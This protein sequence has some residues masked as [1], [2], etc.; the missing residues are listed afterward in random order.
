MKNQGLKLNI[1]KVTV[2]LD[3]FLDPGSWMLDPRNNISEVRTWCRTVEFKFSKKKNDT[4]VIVFMITFR[5][6]VPGTIKWSR[7]TPP[8]VLHNLREKSG[9]EIKY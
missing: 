5:K 9:A 6:I 3:F 7:K 1:D 8:A 2:I 4:V